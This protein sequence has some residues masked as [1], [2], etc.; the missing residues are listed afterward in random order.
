MPKASVD[1]SE[2]GP[3]TRPGAGRCWFARLTPEQ[4]AKVVGAHEL[5]HTYT[6]IASVVTGWGTP[7]SDGTVGTH[8]R[9]G[10]ACG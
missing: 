2:F 4:Q 8:F 1:L 7:V 9:K 5:G 10:C 3:I 6:R